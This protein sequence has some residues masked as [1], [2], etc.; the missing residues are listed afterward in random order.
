MHPCLSLV[1]VEEEREREREERERER[2]GG[3]LLAHNPAERRERERETERLSVPGDPAG[4]SSGAGRDEQNAAK[5]AEH[6]AKWIPPY[7]A[8]HHAAVVGELP[9]NRHVTGE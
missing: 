1:C 4:D 9:L 8:A 6:G 2:E 3:N 7:P 5:D